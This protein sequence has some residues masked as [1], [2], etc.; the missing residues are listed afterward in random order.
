[1]EGMMEMLSRGKAEMKDEALE[2]EGNE[3]V[4]YMMSNHELLKRIHS[5]IG[6]YKTL[7][8]EIKNVEYNRRMSLEDIR[9]PS[10][11]ERDQY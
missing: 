5:A 1:M 9:T 8:E 4:E 11:F 6:E 7:R 2:E 10:K 3:L